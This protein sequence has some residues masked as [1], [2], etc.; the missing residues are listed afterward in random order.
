MK[1]AGIIAEY[2]PFHNGHK[3][4]M[5]ETRR[6]TGADYIIA[7]ISGSF[8]QR[9]GPALLN[10][11]DR[12]FMALQEGADVVI[13]LPLVSALSSAEGF[14]TGGVSLLSHLGVVDVISCGC[15]SAATDRELFVKVLDLL[16]DEPPEYKKA[17]TECLQSGISFP[18]ARDT[19]V[20]D[21]LQVE[22]GRLL[23]EPNNILALEYARAIRR[24]GSSLKLRMIPRQGSSHNDSELSGAYSSASSIRARLL[25][26]E[27]ADLDCISQAVPSD[28]REI[29]LE[30]VRDK[31]CLSEDDFSDLL[32]YAL[33]EKQGMLGKFGPEN[34]D[35]SRRTAQLLEEF[36]CWTDFTALLKTK[37]QTYT[38][39]SRY[40]A[41]VLLNITR[42]DLAHI[43]KCQCV[44]YARLLGFRS[45]AAPLIAEIQRKA[46]IPI[47]S[48]L[49]KEYPG[50]DDSCRHYLDLDLNASEIYRHV[51]YAHSGRRLKSEFR[52]PLITIQ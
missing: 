22:T 47:L 46:D 10:K 45:D 24:T 27:D 18:K 44:P 30:S 28:A 23:S 3:F 37:N 51:L 11:Y 36:T 26:E 32:F 12:A 38:A 43:A 17:L 52:Q 13:E 16:C 2:N 31:M 49:A 9:G 15:E 33:T 19:A 50:L 7:V 48:Q 1:T 42:E 39:V 40:L 6:L 41:H 29:L 8:V 4:H 25:S 14:A 5:E 34:P 35:L 21:V 20:Y